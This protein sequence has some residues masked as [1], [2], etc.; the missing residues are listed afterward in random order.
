[1]KK[2]LLYFTSIVLF[3]VTAVNAQTTIW[4]IGN[5]TTVLNDA[6]VVTGDWPVGP[7]FASETVVKGLGIFP[8]TA[9]TFGAIGTQSSGSFSDSYSAVNRFPTGGASGGSATALPTSR[10][11]YFNVSGSCTIKIW[12]KGGNS[13]STRSLFVSDG[14]TVLQSGASVNGAAVIVEKTV[15]AAG[16]YY[17]YCD[18]GNNIYKIEIVGATVNTPALS[19]DNFQKESQ[20]NVY[21]KE[22]KIFLS[23]VKS[24]T[25]VSV[26]TVA[27]AL[28]KTTETAEDTSID[29]KAGVYVVKA[30]SE[31]GTKSVKVIVQ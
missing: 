3:S 19:T 13:T 15:S 22:N 9:T 12:F 23:N 26:Y 17:V 27:G 31:E 5:N 14:T 21:A 6:A 7:A 30:S 18:N 20:V 10:Y 4:D 11:V 2:K 28:V 1:M 8:G 29:V 24:K 25:A 16:K